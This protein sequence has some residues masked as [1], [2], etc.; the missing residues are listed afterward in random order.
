MFSPLKIAVIV[1]AVTAALATGGAAASNPTETVR[2][3]PV[4]GSGVSGSAPLGANGI[5]TRVA[6]RVTGLA[7]G[8]TARILLRVGRWPRLSASFATAVTVRA[9]SKGVAR[10]TSAVRYRNE[11]VALSIVA[12]SN[13]ILPIVPGGRVVA[14]A[15]LPG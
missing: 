4:A 15:S 10:A 6:A 1:A 8:A 13:H 11:P 7:P 9:D 5:G 14:G 12:D 3:A 2:F